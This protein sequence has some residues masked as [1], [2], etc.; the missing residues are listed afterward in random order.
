MGET[1]Y[2]EIDAYDPVN[3][4]FTSSMYGDDGSKFSGT[5]T[6]SGNTLTWA[7]KFVVGGKPYMIREPFVFAAN[8]MSATAKAEISVDG[9]TW[10]PFFEAKFTK[11]KPASKK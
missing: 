8:L 4:N 2:L 5:V 6:V 11:A 10:T 7:G 1:Q 3:K 9:K